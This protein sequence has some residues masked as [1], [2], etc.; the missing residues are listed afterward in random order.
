MDCVMV[1]HISMLHYSTTDSFVAKPQ[2]VV[3][4]II[5]DR[6]EVLAS[7]ETVKNPTV[8]PPLDSKNG[9]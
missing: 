5:P 1:T 2:A 9:I 6:P 4:L 7:G 3:R 8:S